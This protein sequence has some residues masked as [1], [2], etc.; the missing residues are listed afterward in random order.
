MNDSNLI[1]FVLE[2]QFHVYKLITFI[3][4]TSVFIIRCEGVLGKIISLRIE[5]KFHNKIIKSYCPNINTLFSN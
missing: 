3:K 2:K 1:I 5:E 4:E